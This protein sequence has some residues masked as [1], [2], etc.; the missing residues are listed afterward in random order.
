MKLPLLALLTSLI[1]TPVSVLA[2]AL[3]AALQRGAVHVGVSLFEPWTL[4]DKDGDL[5]GFEIEVGRQ[6]A[7]DLGVDVKFLVYEWKDIIPALQKG[8]I[9]MIAAGM[10]I[11]PKRALQ[12]NFSQPY[13]SSGVTLAA[14]LQ[15]TKNVKSLSQLNSKDYTVISVAGTLAESVARN[16]FAESNHV[17]YGAAEEAEQA[18]RQGKAHV[19]V[20]SIPKALALSLSYPDTVDYPLEKPLMGSKAGFAVRKGEQELLNFLNAWIVAREAD[21]WLPLTYDRWFKSLHW[22]ED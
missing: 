6:L 21:G 18:L 16:L 8:E 10:A 1:L 11:T 12:L 3:D 20:T 2:N 4:K 7:A 22:R 5:I 19:F 17:I 14:N 9:D 13:M 15:K